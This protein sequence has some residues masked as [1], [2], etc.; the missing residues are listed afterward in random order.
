VCAAGTM[1]LELMT[2]SVG[3]YFRDVAAALALGDIK[4]RAWRWNEM[5]HQGLFYGTVFV[6]VLWLFQPVFSLSFQVW[7]RWVLEHF[8]AISAGAAMI[9]A[10]L[11]I[12]LQNHHPYEAAL[13]S[14]S[15]FLALAFAVRAASPEERTPAK[16]A[17]LILVCLVGLVTPTLD[18]VALTRHSL[19][20]HQGSAAIAALAKTPWRDLRIPRPADSSDPIETDQLV[21]AALAGSPKSPPSVLYMEAARMAEAVDY[22]HG[23]A[24]HRDIVFSYYFANEFPLLLGLRTPQ[25]TMQWWDYGRTFADKAPID[26]KI[27]LADTTI[28]LEPKIPEAYVNSRTGRTSRYA[29]RLYGGYIE[30]NFTP[31]AELRY[32]R[33][34]RRTEPVSKMLD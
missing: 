7:R 29:W 32:W 13:L 12:L 2:S 9:G 20:S 30:A 28:F 1:T 6:A 11:T 10:A 31:T 23:R 27:L 14:A 4:E 17:G 15:A 3:P 8:K 25:T 21:K 33:I 24:A 19:I 16:R 26:P 18:I 22:L 5:L 34:W